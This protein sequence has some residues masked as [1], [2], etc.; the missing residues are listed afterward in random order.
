VTACSGR[1]G[2][3]ATP[4]WPASARRLVLVLDQ[5]PGRLDATARAVPAVVPGARI[6][7]LD[8]ASR[9]VSMGTHEAGANPPPDV[10]LVRAEPGGWA[11]ASVLA[12]HHPSRLGRPVD[13]FL[14]AEGPLEKFSV[15]IT[16]FPGLRLLPPNAEVA[17]VVAGLVQSNVAGLGER[18]VRP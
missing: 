3:P 5:E 7:V 9:A 12:A 16:D 2:K 18:A 14:V 10:V 1:R 11:M 17:A 4:T 13:A 6:L 8:A 15:L